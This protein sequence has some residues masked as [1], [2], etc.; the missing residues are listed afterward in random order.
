MN[1]KQLNKQL[2]DVV[3]DGDLEKV[4]QECL[5]YIKEQTGYSLELCDHFT[6]L[7][8]LNGKCYFNVILKKQV[9]E[10]H[11]YDVLL[12]L[13]RIHNIIKVEPNGYKKVAI[14]CQ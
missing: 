6:G 5:K 1:K 3:K 14:I 7:K 8:L 11:I 9:S 12:N 4:K 10:S 2:L 13:S